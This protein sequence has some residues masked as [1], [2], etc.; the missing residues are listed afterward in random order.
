MY[1]SLTDQTEDVMGEQTEQRLFEWLLEQRILHD[2]GLL[3]PDKVA[4]LNEVSPRWDAPLSHDEMGRALAADNPDL[5]RAFESWWN[6]NNMSD[7]PMTFAEI[8]IKAAM[9]MK[10]EPETAD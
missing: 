10:E 4:Y 6:L 7:I 2:V 8:R 1:V 3:E 9:E 5:N